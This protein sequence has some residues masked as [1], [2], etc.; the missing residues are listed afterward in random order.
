M[1]SKALLLG[2]I[3][4][5]ATAQSTVLTFTNVPN[6]IT[7]GQPQAIT[8]ATN[9]TTT[10]V[11]IILRQGLRTDLQDV[12]TLTTEATGGQFI[13]TPPNSLPNGNDYALQIK[14]GNEINYYGPFT[15]Q[16]QTTTSSARSSASASA[17]GSPIVSANSTTSAMMTP[18]GTG[19]SASGTGSPISRNTTMS[20]ATLTASTTSSNSRATASSTDDAGFQGTGTSSA[21][22]EPTGAASSMQIGSSLALFGAIAAGIF[23]Q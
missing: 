10:P 20:S 18:M 11:T 2:A 5:L 19:A 8:Y 17:S 14:Q 3:A 4:A 13:W 9:D 22:S 15:V 7:D 1:F 21:G 23:M 6:P 12:E 16:G